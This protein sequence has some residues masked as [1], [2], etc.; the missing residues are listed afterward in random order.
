MSKTAKP[1]STD[2]LS[3]KEAQERF[4]RTV[5]NMLNTPPR[6][7]KPAQTKRKRPQKKAAETYEQFVKDAIRRFPQPSLRPA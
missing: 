3:P 7:H 2:A 6:P 1:K 4:E 5:K